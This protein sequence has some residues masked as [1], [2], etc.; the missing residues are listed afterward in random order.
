MR[1][2]WSGAG[3]QLGRALLAV[4]VTF[5]LISWACAASASTPCPETASIGLVMSRTSFAIPKSY[6]FNPAA[7]RGGV[8]KGVNLAGVLPGL[9]PYGCASRAEKQCR[10]FCNRV[11]FS[12][13]ER[14][15]HLTVARYLEMVMLESD[16]LAPVMRPEQSGVVRVPTK[17]PR[18]EV[19]LWRNREGRDAILKCTPDG[20]VPS[21]GCAGFIDFTDQLVIS[22]SFAKAHMAEASTIAAGV[23]RQVE[24]FRE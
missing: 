23:V 17:K 11:Y 8:T 16:R 22:F 18:D 12:I 3:S 4:V 5:S 21:P 13:E 20:T 6:F 9:R 14:G 24:R 10:G 2:V 19:W 7:A 15:T 1:L